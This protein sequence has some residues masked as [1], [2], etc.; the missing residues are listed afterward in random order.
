MARQLD[1]IIVIDVEATCWEGDPPANQQSEII[2]IGLCLV[3]VH[4]LTI[5]DTEDIVVNPQLSTVSAYC[6]QL[7]SLTQEEVEKGIR[8]G[9]ACRKLK[10]EYRAAN[11]MWASWGD[12]DRR[13]FDRQCRISD[14]N[15][16]YPFGAT[17]LNIK[18]LFAVEESLTYEV[19]MEQ[20]LAK[21]GMELKGHHHRGIDDAMSI[22][23]ILCHLLTRPDR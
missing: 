18:N 19:G 4:S 17:H 22:A 15:A 1:K 7:T 16:R 8:F 11:R 14:F 9:E 12:Y 10:S 21:L 6:T 3:D 5:T 13:Q 2:E 20:A 23:K